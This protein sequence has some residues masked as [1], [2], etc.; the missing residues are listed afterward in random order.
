MMNVK[1][2]GSSPGDSA[3]WSEVRWSRHYHLRPK[4]SS[5]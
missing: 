3:N 2:F 4:L 5:A 1:T